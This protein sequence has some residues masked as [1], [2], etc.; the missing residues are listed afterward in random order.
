[1]YHFLQSFLS[2]FDLPGRGRDLWARVRREVG[3]AGISGL[4]WP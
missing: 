2:N 4:S 1:M 3:Q